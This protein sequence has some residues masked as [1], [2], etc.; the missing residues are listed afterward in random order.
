MSSDAG[1]RP[2]VKGMTE[3]PA[4]HHSTQAACYF[5]HNCNCN[6]GTC[7]EPP[8][9]RPR[10]HH[11]VNLYL[12]ARRQNE[13]EMFSDHDEMSPSI[14]GV[15]APSAAC[16]MLA[17]QKNLSPIRVKTTTCRRCRRETVRWSWLR[18][19]ELWSAA[20]D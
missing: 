9:R 13:T 19:V 3:H 18:L 16:S 2:E 15:S 7:I 5:L 4:K 17:V 6:W 10:A 11:R 14:V 1:G 20:N 12:G 8:N